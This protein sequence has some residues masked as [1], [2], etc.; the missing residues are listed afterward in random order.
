[1]RTLFLILAII[2]IYLILRHFST[3]LKKDAESPR[4]PPATGKDIPA[5]MLKCDYCGVHVPAQEAIRSEKHNFC[6]LEHK[7]SFK[8]RPP[9]R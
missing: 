7:L 9:E 8:E 2:A 3:R 6:S 1:M 4:H 5:N